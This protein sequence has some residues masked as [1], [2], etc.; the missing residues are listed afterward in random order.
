MLKKNEK[1]ESQILKTHSAGLEPRAE[2]VPFSNNASSTKAK[3]KINYTKEGDTSSRH[4]QKSSST[5]KNAFDKRNSFV[6]KNNNSGLDVEE[7]TT[8][9]NR[10][11]SKYKKKVLK[12][13]FFQ[14]NKNS[15]KKYFLSLR[16]TTK[17]IAE[18]A[19]LIKGGNVEHLNP[20]FFI[21]SLRQFI[22]LIKSIKTQKNSL[23]VVRKKKS[24]YWSRKKLGF[25]DVYKKVPVL[26]YSDSKYVRT[27][28]N[29]GL[30]KLCEL[31][32][33]A[34]IFFEV[35]GSKELVKSTKMKKRYA[36]VI[37][38]TNPNK[39]LLK[40]CLNNRLFVM[41]MFGNLFFN[42]VQGTYS[43]PLT[44]TSVKHC[45]WLI[46]LLNAI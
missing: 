23:N 29:L 12:K 25:L 33:K 7:T 41:S 18:N 4:S 38:L 36:L 15:R 13:G 32:K 21:K 14:S 30:Q 1:I 35:G 20:D 22:R 40:F 6:Y 2:K 44:L 3:K 37:F 5:K 31:D 16:Y 27:V 19:R 8:K 39:S 34:D 42:Q 17:L 43:V 46:T 45:I 9:V 26:I 28:F 24:T 11:K 10:S